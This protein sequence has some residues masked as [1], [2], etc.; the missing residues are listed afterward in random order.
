[1]LE[2]KN[3]P[4]F[5]QKALSAKNQFSIRDMDGELSWFA[6]TQR[7]NA[8]LIF[9]ERSKDKVQPP[10]SPNELFALVVDGAI[11]CTGELA[12][13]VFR[14]FMPELLSGME[15]L[16]GKW[17]ELDAQVLP[18]IQQFC[19]TELE[20]AKVDELPVAHRQ[21]IKPT[22]RA[23]ALGA[24]YDGWDDWYSGIFGAPVLPLDGVIAILAGEAD[25]KAAAQKLCEKYKL[26][27]SKSKGLIKAVKELAAVPELVAPWEMDLCSRLKEFR[28]EVV[29]AEFVRG[30]STA[31]AKILGETVLYKLVNQAPFYKSNF[32]QKKEGQEVIETLCPEKSSRLYCSD[33]SRIL[34]GDNVLYERNAG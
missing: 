30:R 21:S 31:S 13:R 8:K 20:P 27:M 1:M 33:I 18:I 16:L 34:I 9:W 6:V 4:E 29:I 28:S 17:L 3:L 12:N 25:A 19:E 22:A 14:G 32:E 5:A 11:Y 23:L 10:D 15:W 24:V 7:G 26:E 2:E